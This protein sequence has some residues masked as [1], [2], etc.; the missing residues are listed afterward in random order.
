[1][2]LK[3]QIAQLHNHSLTSPLQGGAAVES[4]DERKRTP[5]WY[6]AAYAHV[7]TIEVLLSMGAKIKS[8]DLEGWTP[9]HVAARNGHLAVCR[10]LLSRENCGKGL[11]LNQ[12]DKSGFTPL[13]KVRHFPAPRC[14]IQNVITTALH[15]MST[16]Y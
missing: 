6:A 5:L 4:Q 16:K 3:N 13:H 7:E 2:L 14:R 11:L 1:M 12:A 10:E 8:S 15:Q 9:L